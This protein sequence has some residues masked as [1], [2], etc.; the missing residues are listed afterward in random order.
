LYVF[1]SSKDILLELVKPY[2][3][4]LFYYKFDLN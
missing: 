4:D 1:S 2:L 3:I